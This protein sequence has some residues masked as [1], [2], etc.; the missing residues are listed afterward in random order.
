[1]STVA[2]ALP[3]L[4]FLRPYTARHIQSSA[5]RS[6][7]SHACSPSARKAYLR[8]YQTACGLTEPTPKRSSPSLLRRQIT[9][10]P[11]DSRLALSKAGN[12]ATKDDGS[13]TA[14]DSTTPAEDRS[15][16]ALRIKE[17]QDANVLSYP[18]Y[19]PAGDRISVPQFRTKFESVAVGDEVPY[20]RVELSGRVLSVQRL[21]AKLV[22]LKLL[23][24]GEQVQVMCNLRQLRTPA[25][26]DSPSVAVET[27]VFKEAA[28]LLNRG[29]HVAVTG[30]AMRTGTGELT[31]AADMLPRVYSPALAPLP[32]QLLDGDTRALRRHVDLLV[33]PAAAATLRLRSH[34]LREMR[35]F[36]EDQQFVEVQTPILADLSGGAVA[37]PF[38]TAHATEDESGTTATT[39][40]AGTSAGSRPL[41][42]RIAP[43]LWLKR[44]VV[45][46]LDRV[47]EI[48][49]SFRNEGID[50]THNPE[51]S[52]CEFYAA[53]WT[54]PR[55]MAETEK[56]MSQLAQASLQFKQTPGGAGL[57]PASETDSAEQPSNATVDSVARCAAGGPFVQLEFIPSLEAAL[58]FTFPDLSAPDA[59][60]QLRQKLG[61]KS[62]E[63]DTSDA[64]G[65]RLA[66]LLDRLAGDHLES[67]SFANVDGP[68]FITHHPACMSPLAK[69][70][71]CPKTGQTIAARAELF[72]DG[73]ELANMYE[74][75]N[76]PAEQR[77]KM[78]RQVEDTAGA[79]NNTVD[80]NYIAALESGLPPTGG[81]G[82]GVE[83]LVML[84]SGSRR[85]AD[86]LSFGTLR[87]VVAMKK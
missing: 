63:H 73:R 19:Q 35:S 77:R 45:G 8:F 17:L 46:G 31:L 32:T 37:R 65:G 62:G 1:M 87:H 40:S 85:I 6:S 64:D 78:A 50:A 2:Q 79:S 22:F 66:K 83:R 53:Y 27:A 36:F 12:K 76:D 86:C 29:D 81:W 18:R 55:L 34:I 70:F 43:E 39:A 69:S 72:V 33:N 42:L 15:A 82:C 5:A 57:L 71:V 24:E 26:G 44:L 51:F 74:E 23:D 75:E 28:R 49:Q 11:C 20:H 84:F 80:E 7:L 9:T 60:D 41:S 56:L 3:G 47:F 67:R 48:G 38:M 21:G 16:V 58:G 4:L 52:T 59:Y 54:L 30:C 68:L 10:R 13:E 61:N 14:S 25:Q